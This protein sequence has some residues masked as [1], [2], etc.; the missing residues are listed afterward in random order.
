MTQP[1]RVLYV[2]DNAH[3]RAL[4][5]DALEQEDGGFR[6]TEAT[7][8]AEFETLLERGDFDLVLSD[9][10]IL[11]FEGLQ[12]VDAAQARY[13][14]IP[15]VIVTGTGSEETAVAAMKHGA[16]DYVVKS[17]SHIRHLPQT[18]YAVLERNRMREERKRN[19]TR[20]REAE[21]RNR[22]ILD[23][24]LEAIVTINAEGTIVEFNPAAERMFGY[25]SDE[26]LGQRMAEMIIPPSQRKAHTQGLERYLATGKAR[27]LGRRTE[28]TALRRDGTEFPMELSIQRV[29]EIEPPLFTGFIRDIS[30]RKEAESGLLQSQERLHHAV[31]AG[32]VGLWDWDLRTNL[33]H[34]SPDWTRQMGYE[35]GEIPGGF[36]E[37][38]SR[39]HPDDL[40]PTVQALQRYLSD[41]ST[42]YAVEFRLCHKDG[43]WRHILARGSKTLDENGTPIR[44]VGTHVDI[45]ERVHMEAQLLQTNKM[46]SIGQLAGGIA[47]DFNNLLTVILGTT[48]F[49][50]SQLRE[51]DPMKEH[52]EQIR[53]AGERAAT[54]TR[55]LLAFSRNQIL[56]LD[57]LNLSRLI[58]GLQ[59]M[60]R[61]LIDENI[62]LV[63]DLAQDLGNVKVD[64]AQIEQVIVNLAANARDAMPDG[65]QLTIETRNVEI[66]EEEAHTR[67]L[68]EPGPY[69]ML[70]VSDTGV[71]IDDATRERI[72]EPF[73][74]TKEMGR[75][76]GLG[77]AT[78]Y[79]IIRQS[80][81]TILVTSEP[82]SGTTFEIYLPRVEEV[83]PQAE[84]VPL[85]RAAE[86]ES[87][88]A[89]TI[90]LVEDDDALR[91]L[92]GQ[93]LQMEGYTIIAAS[94]GAEALS[95]LGNH[96]G[97]VD[98]L[99]TDLIM[100]GMNGRDLAATVIE[101]RPNIKIIFTSGYTDDA[102]LRQGVLEHKT[103]FIGKPYTL[104]ELTSL[105]R[106]VL[107]E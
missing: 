75:G 52:L 102:V 12:V 18:L 6:I 9:F 3:D 91:R 92:F 76:A 64:T 17:P 73:F 77:L 74:T 1:I 71:G 90:L 25:R 29:G 100:P 95:L 96:K 14:G 7:T 68:L 93:M 107:G 98:L 104:E 80:N 27:I 79:G 66:D 65:G 78:V 23:S 57:V 13:P 94:N 88:A 84:S 67:L 61:R 89:K 60:L 63:V 21:A 33:V 8:H 37:W 72:F 55:Q 19:E 48:E 51:G 86:A 26:I 34:F 43:S 28:L 50:S 4:V 10:N 31:T 20:L 42:E 41:D 58:A 59:S 2:D 40:F 36:T 35:E 87:S 30:E 69:V 97:N 85:A 101:A 39:V 15:V 49:A 106:E 38:E 24:A 82:G 62:E 45:T 5:R 54:L 53:K 11:G 105:L 22:A 70:V 47:H 83:A 46:A 103:H 81:G 44:M 16:A 56:K 32:R 99:L